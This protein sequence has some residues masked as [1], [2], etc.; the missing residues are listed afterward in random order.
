MAVQNY[1]LINVDAYDPDSPS[2]FPISSLISP[3]DPVSADHIKSLATQ[4]RQQ[5]RGGDAEGALRLAL[6]SAPYGSDEKVMVI[7]TPVTLP[8]ETYQPSIWRLLY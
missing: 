7:I 5:S 2:N 1:R 3:S 6:Q 8:W 4:I